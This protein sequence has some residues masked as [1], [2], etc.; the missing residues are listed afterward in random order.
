MKSSVFRTA[1]VLFLLPISL[2]AAP[3][4]PPG[5][6][7]AET[8]A[9]A[10]D[11]AAAIA[12]LVP[13]TEEHFFYSC[14]LAQ[15]EKRLDEA[16]QLLA[17]WREQHGETAKLAEMRNR[18]MLFR[19]PD[20]PG[21]T[22]AYLKKEL[23]LNFDHHQQ[24]LDA[25]PDFPTTLDPAEITWEAFRERAERAP[26]ISGYTNEGLDRLLR[27]DAPLDEDERRELL[28]RLRHPDS[29]RLVGLIAADL[30]SKES[31]GFGEFAIH[32]RLT[33]A[34]LDELVGLVPELARNRAFVDS[35]LVRL[36][37]S[38]DVSLV[39]EP[40]ERKA[41]LERLWGYVRELDPSFNSL[42]AAVLFRR[43]EQHLDDG[44]HPLELFVEYL[45]LP[46]PTSYMRPEYIQQ[47]AP[48]QGRADISADFAATIGFPPIGNDEP[49]V[50]EFLEHFLAEDEN[51]NRFA[52]YIR[53]DYLDRVFAE[54]KLL[55]GVGD[56]QK[57][58]AMLG[59]GRVEQVKDRV[60]L[61][62]ARSNPEHLLAGDEVSLAI[63]VKNVP[64]LLVKV[65]RINTLNYYL[66]RKEEVG[67]DLNLDGLVANSEQTYRYEQAPVLRHRETFAFPEMQGER[68][69][70]VVEFIG[71]GISSRA[72]VRKGDLQ[73]VSTT[74]PGGELV[75][76]LTETNEPAAAP[77]VWFGGKRYAAREDG[78]VLLPFST[79]GSV[80]IVLE[81]GD[82]TDFARIDLR[83]ES[84]DLEIGIALD[85]ETLLPGRE[86]EVVVRPRLFLGDEP[87]S[88]ALLE[89][90]TLRIETRDADGVASTLE[91]PGFE[92]DEEGESVHRFRVPN[93]LRSVVVSLRGE[94]SLISRPG[95]KAEVGGMEQVAVNGIADTD[96]IEDAFLSRFGDEYVVEVLGRSGEPLAERPVTLQ[97]RDA[98]FSE[99]YRVVLKTDESGRI[100]LGSLAGLAEVRAKPENGSDRFWLLRRSSCT[101]PAVIQATSGEPI[102]VPAPA[103]GDAVD[104]G[105]VALFENRSGIPVRDA[106]ASV[107]VVPGGVSIPEPVPGDYTLVLRDPHGTGADVEIE[108]RVTEAD[109]GAMGYALSES[110]HLQ[111][112]DADPVRIT[113]LAADGEALRIALA[114]GGENVR[115][116]LIATRFLPQHPF[117]N[118]SGGDLP[119]Y[120]VARGTNKSLYLS[121]RDI[122]EEYRYI[123]DRRKAPKFPGNMLPRPGLLLNPWAIDET[124]TEVDE[125]K[126]G[127]DYEKIRDFEKTSR[128]PNPP[129]RP[130]ADDGM[131]REGDLAAFLDFL[132]EPGVV[133]T[134]LE[135]DEAGNI[136]VP[137]DEL[138]D[139]QHFRVVAVDEEQVQWRDLVLGDRETKFRDL[140]LQETLDP[141]KT[142]TQQRKVTLLEEGETLTI[143][144]LRSAELETYATVGEVYDTLA[145]I[146][147]SPEFGK[148][149][150]LRNWPSL[151]DEEKRRLYS[152]FACHELHF[153][154]SRKDTEFFDAVVKPY[155]AN[156][157]DKTFLDRYLLGEELD[158]YLAPW[159]YGR[160]NIVERI[161]LA[162]RIGGDEPGRTLAHV[163]G[164]EE[165]SPPDPSARAGVFRQA[166][167]GRRA[168]GVVPA[169][170]E[171]ALADGFGFGGGAMVADAFADMPDAMPAPVAPAA[172]ADP[173]AAPVDA[174]AAALGVAARG[175]PAGRIMNR[176][177]AVA[178]REEA[179]SEVLYRDLDSTKEWAENN[180]YEIPISQQTGDLITS[181][182]F[183]LDFAEWDGEGGFY[184]REF[185]AATRS[186][187]EAL[188]ALA[189][190]DLPFTA[191]KPEIEVEENELRF[192]ATSPTVIFHEE[193]GEAPRAEGETPVL[194]SQN[195]FRAD[196]RHRYENGMP[197][198]KFVT[199]EFLVGV[200]YGSQIVATNPTSTPRLLELLVQI[201]EGAVP[202]GG[203]DYLE[204]KPLRLAPFSTSQ[205]EVYFYFP[206]ASGN[207]SF[208]LYPVSVSVDGE[209][210][211]TGEARSFRVVD[212]P[213]VFDES[214]WEYLSQF[215]SEKEVLDYL[216]TANL[217]RI[218]LAKVAWRARESVDF[219]RSVT[220]LVGERHGF[221][222]VL[223]SYGIHHG[224]LPVTREYLKHRDDFVSRLGKR[225]E[226]E[227]VSLEP[228]ERHWYE[229]LEYS[230]LVNARAHQLGR[231]RSILNDRFREQY[232]EFLDLLA[233]TPE[234]G[235]EEN[236]ATSGY[237]LLQDRIEEGLDRL[238]RVE[239]GAVESALQHD[240]LR[241]YAAFY[242]G[243]PAEAR[244]IAAAHLDH[245]VERW[246]DRFAAVERQVAGIDGDA[247]ED[248]PEDTRE[249]TLEKLSGDEPYFELTAVGREAELSFRNLDEVTVNYYEMDLEFLFS[250]QPFVSG[251]SGQ[252]SLVQPNATETKELPEGGGALRFAL[253]ERFADRN[254]LV[255]V[256]AAG[257]TS[258]AAVYSNRLD[259]Q[260]AD[261]FGRIEVRHDET[262]APLPRTYVKVYA[263]EK[264]G[265]VTFFKDG[266]TDLRGR[267]DYA[268]LSTD[269][270]DRIDRLSVLVMSEENGAVVKEVDPPQR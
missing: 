254:V 182:P 217:H 155:L 245:P 8:F 73:F 193:I 218:D 88:P 133:L 15:H 93:R 137:L 156:K 35:K 176:R 225:I 4:D 52:P 76:V 143:A 41:H 29:P 129:G 226:C 94:I 203:A 167:R 25:K 154:L 91:V 89:K 53:Q 132:A 153:F 205:D 162:R 260:V 59:A 18:Q 116:H 195:F 188:M 72:L 190:L 246:R 100:A 92:V 5:I 43:L 202:V 121:G 197:V 183:W 70:W 169:N 19:F 111:L 54:T 23:G 50:R 219:L 256:V 255:E 135:P 244:R 150:F 60:E 270:L 99:P 239:P 163:R 191:E 20:R 249:G 204:A 251:G 77:A 164:L 140:R 17:A 222:Q 253:P 241:A 258:S 209:V 79:Q 207:E 206:S 146:Y 51:T 56:P 184:S 46:R 37:P 175:I 141:N 234:L 117:V 131:I 49:L 21:E 267:F 227:L 32:G 145:A 148:F 264:G 112:S 48:L 38:A 84:Y 177:A 114:G 57:W 160:L 243:E 74:T 26:G 215:G 186:F 105:E 14:L 265:G 231:D 212:R 187:A 40:D 36:L 185:P 257:R 109:A 158:R 126:A 34:Q 165:L 224:E 229:H 174:G 82:F 252:F 250:R 120:Q 238:A 62:L 157:K 22:F 192:T 98:R 119:L 194:V 232:G 223:W 102:V 240:Y 31:K 213:T 149:A 24:K 259:L 221:D 179:V 198:D 108:V 168:G 228:V 16:D 13:G 261:R 44:E 66:E 85:R 269:E 247:A 124:S 173:F 27:S 64:E 210:I 263:R 237:L 248:E 189:V 138:G 200:V 69:V 106:T 266:Y 123:L 230:P 216:G 236:L 7:F 71:N 152:E 55:R 28:S 242:R 201:P 214:S 199:E 181:N 233:F 110:R 75:R 97:L 61:E 104:P 47:A 262:G 80:P 196:D 83:E 90:T 67:T 39:R 128:M 159:E 268:S 78:T 2:A 6:G 12:Q 161:L 172:A 45:K 30:R 11:R 171:G 127:E 166:L 139:R 113:S 103:I 96:L 58:F 86:A 151:A 134:N 3:G 130:G 95:E 180:Y 81:D 87:V 10:D 142:F 9:L 33:A 136:V 65:Y 211:G 144:D 42:K 115:V 1:A 118:F 235:A 147:G 101:H 178:L 220:Q 208:A 170:A 125:A 122:G 68:G 63:D 107:R